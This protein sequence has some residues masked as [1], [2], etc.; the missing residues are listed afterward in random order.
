MLNHSCL[1]GIADGPLIKIL[2]RKFPAP[3]WINDALDLRREQQRKAEK[4]LRA[5]P[6]QNRER[7]LRFFHLFEVSPALVF[8]G[9]SVICGHGE[10][11]PEV[12]QD[13]PDRSRKMMRDPAR[14]GGG[15]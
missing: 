11:A 7:T 9:L 5:V 4:V 15:V 1:F 8:C 3:G 2:R 10:S 14:F 13:R 12:H 6:G